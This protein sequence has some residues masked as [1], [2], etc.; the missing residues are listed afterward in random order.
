M[1]KVTGNYDEGSPHFTSPIKH[2]GSSFDSPRSDYTASSN[3]V[4]FYQSESYSDSVFK[5]VDCNRLNNCTGNDNT[6]SIFTKLINK[7]SLLKITNNPDDDMEIL[8]PSTNVTVRNGHKTC[9]NKNQMNIN[10]S[11]SRSKSDEINE[12]TAL[13]QTPSSY[14]SFQS[15][16][17][18]QDDGIPKTGFEFLDNW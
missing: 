3:Q 4:S 1:P 16:Q 15:S 7:T 14:S 11:H 2:E 6:G 9:G 17:T 13:L 12:S 8:V 5:N 10:L 18:I